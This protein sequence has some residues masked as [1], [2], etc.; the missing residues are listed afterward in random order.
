M[1]LTRQQ[2][3]IIVENTP[4]ELK[5]QQMRLEIDFGS[6]MKSNANWSYRAGY[7][8]HNGQMVLVVTVF[9]EVQ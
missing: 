5:G 8:K 2:I 9:G 6:Y 7:V 1:K 3:N 4:Q